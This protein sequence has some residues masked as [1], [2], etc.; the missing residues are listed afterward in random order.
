MLD[1]PFRKANLFQIGSY[2]FTDHW[3]VAAEVCFKIF[4]F[5]ACTFLKMAWV[6]GWKLLVVS[7]RVSLTLPKLHNEG[8]VKRKNQTRKN[9]CEV[10]RAAA[11][12]LY[13]MI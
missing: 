7:Q 1:G 13:A 9:P 3:V 8:S 2:I 5:L 10:E 11:A 6:L 4:L 12:I